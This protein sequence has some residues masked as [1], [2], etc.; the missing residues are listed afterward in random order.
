MNNVIET[1][2]QN[3]LSVYFVWI[4][5]TFSVTFFMT[6]SV[7]EFYVHCCLVVKATLRLHHIITHLYAD[8][9]CTVS[10]LTSYNHR[11]DQPV[12]SGF[13]I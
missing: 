12:I 8:V 1:V 6:H 10:R 3:L 9:S 5:L 13:E 7:V 4:L 2:N 11:Q